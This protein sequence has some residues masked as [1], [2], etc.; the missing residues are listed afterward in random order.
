[1]LILLAGAAV[2]A[3][4]SLS[5]LAFLAG[6]WRSTDG[7]AEEVWTHP[8]ATVMVGAGRIEVGP[9]KVCTESLRIEADASGVRYVASPSGQAPTVFAL[10]SLDAGRAVFENP[11]HD[12]PQRIR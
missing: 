2:A 6:H 7:H 11:Q 5:D 4:P 3:E 12:F 8:T 1:M 10:T 9:G